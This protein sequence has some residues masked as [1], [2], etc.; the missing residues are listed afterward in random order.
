MIQLFYY[1]GN[2]SLTPH[3]LLEE[4]GAPFELVLVDR[5]K[6]AHKS[7][8]YLKLNPNGQIPVLLNDGLVLY[9]TARLPVPSGLA[10]RAKLAPP[11]Q[12]ADGPLHQWRLVC[13]RAASMLMHYFY[14]D[15]GRRW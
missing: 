9:E 5:A 8:E 3:I 7:T 1:P 2:A 10:S 12:T 4:I 6:A 11:L 13:Q 15:A 14:G